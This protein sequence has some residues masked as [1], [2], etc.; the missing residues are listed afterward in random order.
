MKLLKLLFARWSAAPATDAPPALNVAVADRVMETTDEVVVSRDEILGPRARLL[1]YRFRTAKP[2]HRPIAPAEKLA[3]LHA[4][5]VARFG[6]RRTAVV[7]IDP[8]EWQAAPFA[9]LAT[10]GVIFLLAFSAPASSASDW[11]EA[12]AGIRQSGGR[13]GIAA[14]ALASHPAL[15]RE[16]DL[17]VIDALASSL[18]AFD[19]QVARIRK[20]APQVKIAADGIAT[21]PE[22]RHA[23]EIGVDWCLGG[24]AATLDID[25]RSDTLDA[26][27]QSLADIINLLRR[28]ADVAEIVAAA[29]RDAAI[30]LRLLEMANSPLSGATTPI[31]SVQQALLLLGREPVYRWVVLS[32]YRAGGDDTRNETLL[33]LAL[34][35]ARFMEQVAGA[36]LDRPGCD[37]LFLVGMVSLLDCLLG[38]PMP[39]LLNRIS[40]PDKVR[41]VLLDSSGPYAKYL[42]LALAVEKGRVEQQATLAASLGIPVTAVEAAKSAAWAWTD[43]AMASAAKPA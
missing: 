20:E 1:G 3:A 33:E 19:R 12:I 16:V 27:R 31:A 23:I 42:L 5:Q 35:R 17:V 32:L 28:Q 29:K 6:D 38:M 37:E 34:N 7:A 40:V 14:A 11:Q 9:E 10:P 43:Q 4:D 24:F 21:W 8:A 2:D 22:Y 15:A 13:V 36:V 41:D 25:R 39:Q 18:A 26:G 30:A